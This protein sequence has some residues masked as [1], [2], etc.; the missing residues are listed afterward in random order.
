MNQRR[1][2]RNYCHSPPNWMSSQIAPRASTLESSVQH[3]ATINTHIS[4]S[5]SPRNLLDS[6]VFFWL[7]VFRALPSLP[8][9]SD[10]LKGTRLTS[11]V[12][13]R[14]LI[15]FVCFFLLCFNML[16]LEVRDGAREHRPKYQTPEKRLG[17]KHPA[18]NELID[19]RRAR[20]IL[21]YHSRWS[22]GWQQMVH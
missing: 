12:Q 2:D 15:C 17:T 14:R 8:L 21:S 7:L 4:R 13:L 19:Q 6:E 22:F 3:M 18:Q 1:A 11:E 5:E 9:P 20:Q 10:R 16:R